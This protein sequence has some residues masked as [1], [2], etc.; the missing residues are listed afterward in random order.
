L[1]ALWL[2][3]RRDRLDPL[4]LLFVSG[5][6]VVVVGGITGRYALGRCWPAVLL[7]GQ[8]ALAVELA[9]PVPRRLGRVWIPATAAA[10]L[11]GLAVQFGN[12]LYV[13]PPSVLTPAV[14]QAAHM[15][16]AWP[17]YSWLN[18][19]VRPGE[20]VLAPEDYYGARTLP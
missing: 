12:L 14:R 4:V 10:C 7:A 15:Y 8:L 11:A 1:P 2:R 17:D 13:A 16:V 9:G 6:A 19:Y 18:R 5:L 20:V 3:W